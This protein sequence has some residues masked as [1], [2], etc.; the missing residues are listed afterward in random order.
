M[1]YFQS[2]D[3]SQTVSDLI[4]R[5]AAESY[6]YIYTD[7]LYRF[8]VLYIVNEYVWGLAVGG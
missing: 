3:V 7:I 2:M 8:N 4:G 1:L 5:V 6:L